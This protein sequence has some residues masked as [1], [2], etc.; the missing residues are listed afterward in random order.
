M[1]S[2]LSVSPVVLEVEVLDLAVAG[3]IAVRLA[4]E[5]VPSDPNTDVSGHDEASLAHCHP[6]TGQ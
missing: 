4:I 2:E 5:G 6:N 3:A 1:S